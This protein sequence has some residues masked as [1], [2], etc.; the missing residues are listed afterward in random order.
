MQRRTMI[1]SSLAA[2]IGA[3]SAKSAALKIGHRQ[4]NM[5]ENPGPEV[6]DLARK[7]AGLSGVELQIQY[8]GTSLWDRD[9]LQS[10]KQAAQR[11]G[12][13]VPSLAGIWKPGATIMQPRPGR[14][15]P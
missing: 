7:I 9:T 10:Y 5:I 2:A 11:T 4:A 8:K 12:L 14:G 15:A 3:A 1:C 13:A 6:F